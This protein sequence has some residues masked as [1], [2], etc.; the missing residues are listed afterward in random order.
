MDALFTAIMTAF[1]AD[2]TMKAALVNGLH[3]IE[4]P[5][6]TPYPYGT[7]ELISSEPQ[8][9]FGDGEYEYDIIGFQLF[10]ESDSTNEIDAMYNATD[11]VYDKGTLTITGF[12]FVSMLRI[13]RDLTKDED[14]VNIYTIDYEVIYKKN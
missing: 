4:V 12:T 13:A 3:N 1:N 14:G 6:E 7:Y 8:R 5:Q 11:A 9:T 10:S 2:T